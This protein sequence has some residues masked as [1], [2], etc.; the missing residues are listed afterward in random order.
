MQHHPH[1]GACCSGH[2]ADTRPGGGEAPTLALLQSDR[3]AEAHLRVS[4]VR[5]YAEASKPRR[6]RQPGGRSARLLARAG[7]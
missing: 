6:R 3:D 4:E 1:D 2:D 7:R 5:C